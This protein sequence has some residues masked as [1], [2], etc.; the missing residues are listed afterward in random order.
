MHPFLVR[1]PLSGFIPHR[2]PK[3]ST[4]FGSCPYLSLSFHSLI[5]GA[6]PPVPCVLVVDVVGHTT[7]ITEGHNK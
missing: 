5:V 6:V 4:S 2:L 1:V 7:N 3:I